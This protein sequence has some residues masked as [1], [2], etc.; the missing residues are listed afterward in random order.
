MS[1]YEYEFKG[2]CNDTEVGIYKGS[3]NPG[4]N[5][6]EKV[7]NCARECTS[8]R[9]KPFKGKWS[10]HQTKGFI[11][12]SSGRCFCEDGNSKSCNKVKNGYKRYDFIK[13]FYKAF[14]GE[15]S[16]TELGIYKGSDNPGKNS[17]ERATFCAKEC[18]ARTKKLFKGKWK[19]HK[20]KGFIVNPSSGRCFCEEGN[21][22]TCKKVKNNYVRFDFDEKKLKKMIAKKAKAKAAAKAAKAQAAKAAKA[23]AAKAKAAAKAAKAAAKAAKAAKEAKAKAKAA[24]EKKALLKKY[25]RK[26]AKTNTK[27]TKAA[28]KV[29][30]A[31]EIKKRIAKLYKLIAT[32]SSISSKEKK[33]VINTTKK[34]CT[35][36]NYVNDMTCNETQNIKQFLGL[37]YNEELSFEVRKFIANNILSDNKK[38]LKMIKDFE[39]KQKQDKENEKKIEAER[40]KNEKLKLEEKKKIEKEEEEKRKNKIKELGKKKN[41]QQ[42]KKDDGQYINTL[43]IR[44]II[45]LVFLVIIFHLIKMFT[46]NKK[47]ESEDFDF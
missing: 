3:D 28:E 17:K 1:N 8:R 34:Y 39:D 31:D 38:E 30:S 33:F 10:G 47:N 43:I 42:K 29:L 22:K 20:T 11:V 2:E 46:G 40:K 9:K 18:S 12:E 37:N 16:D 19:G 7:E 21:S 36:K 25:Q 26:A 44:F 32:K 45:G 27:A 15:C 14:K 23:K 24:K 13:P 41:K 5:F 4:K 6:E 35:H